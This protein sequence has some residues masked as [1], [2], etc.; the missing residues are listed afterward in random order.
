MTSKVLL[1]F[2]HWIICGICAEC[3]EA[4]P[5]KT[6]GGSQV[7]ASGGCTLYMKWYWLLLADGKLCCNYLSEI[8][9]ATF[10][11]AVMYCDAVKMWR[12]AG[13]PQYSRPSPCVICGRDRVGVCGLHMEPHFCV[14]K[15]YPVWK[16]RATSWCRNR[17]FLSAT[18][19]GVDE[20]LCL[21]E[22]LVWLILLNLMQGG[23]SFDQYPWWNIEGCFYGNMSI[24]VQAW[25]VKTPRN[26]SALQHQGELYIHFLNNMGLQL[27]IEAAL[28]HGMDQDWRLALAYYQWCHPNGI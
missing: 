9:H 15:L 14:S 2:G 3:K 20:L 8:N 10:F 7:L 17:Y 4:K 26:A 22:A 1:I 12:L 23:T 21:G 11:S 6:R 28:K 18:F 19:P 24:T 16:K 25:N 5:E 27:K 13:R